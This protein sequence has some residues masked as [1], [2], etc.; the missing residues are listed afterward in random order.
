MSTKKG[1]A[2][3]ILSA[4]MFGTMPPFARLIYANGGTPFSLTFHRFLFSFPILFLISKIQKEPTYRPSKKQLVWLIEV[5]FGFIM[6]PL[7][8]YSS[9][10]YISSGMA[11]TLHFVYPVIVILLCSLALKE[12]ITKNQALCCSL[13]IVGI[14]CF[15][16]PD[17]V[18]NFIGIFAALSSGITFAVYIVLLSKNRIFEIPTYQLAAW[19]SFLGAILLLPITIVTGDAIPPMTVPGWILTIL[20]SLIMSGIASVAFQVGTRYCG[21]QAASFASTFEPLTSI[22]LG[23]IIYH[24][25]ITVKISL[26]ILCILCAIIVLSMEK[27]S[28]A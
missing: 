15:Y 10:N 14:L 20:F 26:G 18:G 23:I 24:E 22:I 21:A 11:T 1:L 25:A 3:V 12:A 19:L 7:L 9:Y 28:K 13:C 2:L 27:T 5:C 6:T 4:I 17:G 8:L 16:T